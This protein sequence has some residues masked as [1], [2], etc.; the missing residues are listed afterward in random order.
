MLATDFENLLYLE[1]GYVDL[2]S[3]ELIGS[4]F[5]LKFNKGFFE[6]ENDPR[7]VEDI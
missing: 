5:N 1:N 6:I 3:N 2:K 7:L 4:D